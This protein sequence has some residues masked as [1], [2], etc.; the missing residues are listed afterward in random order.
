MK[1]YRAAL[2]LV[3]PWALARLVWRARAYP[4]YA[5]RWRERLGHGPSLPAGSL[6]IHAV[7]V[8]ETRAG[9]PLIR[10]LLEDYPGIPLVVTT[11]TFTGAAE[12]ERL[13]GDS[14]RHRFAPFDLPRAIARFL[15][16]VQPRAAIILETELWPCLFDALDRARIPLALANVR[17]SERSYRGYRRVR[18]TA[19]ALLQ[20]PSVI[21]AQSGADAN[22]LRALGAPAGRVHVTGNMKFELTHTAGLREAA[23]AL[24]QAWG[25]RPVWVAASTHDG[26]EEW[27]LDAHRR[28]RARHPALLLVLVPRHPER[29]ETAARL[30]RHRG[31][32]FVERS[33]AAP[34]DDDTQVVLGDTMGELSLFFACAECAFIGGSLVPVGGH[35]PL[36]ALA[37][38]VP[39][40]FGPHM[41]NFEE[42]AGLTLRAGAG[43][44][45]AGGEELADAIDAYLAQ[46]ADR[47]AAGRAG[48]ALVQENQG[49][50]TRALALLKPLLDATPSADP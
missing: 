6:W 34:V 16:A 32:A 35:N 3:L 49:A 20:V 26:E 29:F 37:L 8:G 2:W 7:S 18:R 46:R 43:R 11:T 42:I 21:A 30:L 23:Q 45:V 25:M 5:G 17:L 4:R 31:V 12:V 39:V 40:V 33:R 19:R 50:L 44:Q 48:L 22:R 14:V 9:A 41:F 24:H 15:A 27:V 1:A 13:F 28:L 38:G 36:E 47:E 10:R